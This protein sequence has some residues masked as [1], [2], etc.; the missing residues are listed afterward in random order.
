MSRAT[1]ILLSTSICKIKWGERSIEFDGESRAELLR[2][3]RQLDEEDQADDDNKNEEEDVAPFLPCGWKICE[4]AY[5]YTEHQE[6]PLVQFTI[7][8]YPVEAVWPELTFGDGRQCVRCTT[9]RIRPDRSRHY[10]QYSNEHRH[11]GH[12][13]ARTTALKPYRV[14]NRFYEVQFA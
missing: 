2:K 6:S 4:P 7:C 3:M 10:I 12:H 5:E 8:R 9:G 14:K 13:I 11:D 1:E